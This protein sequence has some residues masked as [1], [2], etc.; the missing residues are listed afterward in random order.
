MLFE[1]MI[2]MVIFTETDICISKR[3]I[4]S[5]VILNILVI[6]NILPLKALLL[7]IHVYI[8]FTL[9]NLTILN[10]QSVYILF[11][12]CWAKCYYNNGSHAV[13]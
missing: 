8:V 6:S 9:Y 3:Y 1:R 4:C 2:S 5:E 13:T 11:Q 10:M 12:I 7:M